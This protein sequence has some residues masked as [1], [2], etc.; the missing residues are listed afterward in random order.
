MLA[1]RCNGVGKSYGLGEE[2][3]LQHTL[4]SI[5]RRE[6]N[7]ERFW[8]L[9]DVSFEV[10]RGEMFGIVGSNGSGKSTLTQLI[11]GIAMQDK[12]KIEIWG[13]IVPL[14]E[15]GAGFHPELTGRENVLLYG[16]ILGLSNAA[17]LKEMDRIAEFAGVERHL[18]TPLKRYSSGMQARL[19]FS[20]AVCFPADSYV[21]DEVLSVVDDSFRD[22][23]TEELVRLNREGR[24]IIFM[25][26]NLDMVRSVC[27]TGMWLDRGKIRMRAGIDEVATAYAA[28]ARLASFRS[29]QDVPPFALLGGCEHLA[30]LLVARPL[31]G[32]AGHR[33]ADRR[34]GV[35]RH[36]HE[37][38]GSQIR[39]MPE[40]VH[41]ML[42]VLG[43][44]FERHRSHGPRQA[45]NNLQL[46]S[47]DIDLHESRQAEP[48]D[49]GIEGR[50]FDLPRRPPAEV[51]APALLRGRDPLLRHRAE[52][53]AALGRDIE[54]GRPLR[55]RHALGDNGYPLV[56]HEPPA[57]LTEGLIIRLDCN[58]PGPEAQEGRRVVAHV[59]PNV[60]DEVSRL[61]ELV[62]KAPQAPPK[63]ASLDWPPDSHENVP[64]SVSEAI[65]HLRP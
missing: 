42:A 1:V 52:G 19:S 7:L 61:D 57:Q 23:C 10:K 9:E 20:T 35:P 65:P 64:G 14:L 31:P 24:T 39:Q 43:V 54:L 33:L 3:S 2:L 36:V 11:S 51:E 62:M 22:Q 49:Q 60:E 50:D 48:A 38:R 12:G 40:G 58:D 44:K 6:Y 16:T 26:H 18:D 30:D 4:K 63:V 8:A 27:S 25:S 55:V 47:L 28:T 37:L 46:E 41:D 32:N 45:A 15:V 5:V 21:F 34:Q 56:G 53:G 29:G 13:R 17:I 59:R